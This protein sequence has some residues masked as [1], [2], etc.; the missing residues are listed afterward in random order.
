MLRHYK[1][2]MSQCIF[3]VVC[4]E[5]FLLIAAG[6]P[7]VWKASCILGC[8]KREVANRAREVVV[9]FCTALV[10]PRLKYCIQAWAPQH[11]KNVDLL[12][13][14]EKRATRMIKQLAHFCDDQLKE[15]DL[16]SLWKRRLQRDLIWIL[17]FL[18]GA[19]KQEG[20]ELLLTVTGQGGMVLN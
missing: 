14:V 5:M 4:P 20:D 16:F 6:L 9:P 13:W 7:A 18:K 17:Q 12:E 11:K 8:F 10:R 3:K 19:Y 2:D 15:L 1:I